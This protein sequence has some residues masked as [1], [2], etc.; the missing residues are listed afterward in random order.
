MAAPL[1]SPLN[2]V[3]M[4]VEI[5]SGGPCFSSGREVV[6]QMRVQGQPW[7]DIRRDVRSSTQPL[8]AKPANPTNP[9]N[10]TNPPLL[11]QVLV[12]YSLP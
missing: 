6:V 12:A 10:P 9:T 7:G 5:P 11:P 3:A 8:T 4:L 2:C 1:V